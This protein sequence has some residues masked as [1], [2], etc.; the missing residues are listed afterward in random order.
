MGASN[1]QLNQTR[2]LS[3]SCS[4][5]KELVLHLGALLFSILL[6]RTRPNENGQRWPET[7]GDL[8]GRHVYFWSGCDVLSPPVL[9]FALSRSAGPVLPISHDCH[10]KPWCSTTFLVR[11]SMFS[12]Q[13]AARFSDVLLPFFFLTNQA[14]SCWP[15]NHLILESLNFEGRNVLSTERHNDPQGPEKRSTRM[16]Q[17]RY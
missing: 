13:R 17:Y 9:V 11:C 15:P 5:K 6:K 14:G 7:R 8:G 10:G 16:L 1:L 4:W 12:L 2:S 3:A